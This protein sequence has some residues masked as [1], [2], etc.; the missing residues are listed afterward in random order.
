MVPQGAPASNAS[1]FTPTNWVD[2]TNSP[3]A[4]SAAGNY[5]WNVFDTMYNWVRVVYTDSS[6]GTSTAVI[7]QCNFNG[8]GV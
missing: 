3:Y 8:K 5:M 7:T 6:G 2:I 4:V 1:P